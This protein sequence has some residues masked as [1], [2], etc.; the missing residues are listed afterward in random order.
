MRRLAE[1][2][3]RIRR[4]AV[5]A[6]SAIASSGFANAHTADEARAFAERAVAHIHDVGREQ[7]FADFSRPD[8]GFVDGELYIFC[9]DVTG[10]LL[11]S[12]GSPQMIGHNLADA[13]EPDG[14]RPVVEAIQLGLSQGSGWLDTPW[15]NPIKKRIELKSMYVL[16]VDDRTV[17]G[18]GIY[19]GAS[20]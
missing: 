17:C 7:A 20:P 18:S 3:C 12:G 14:R 1:Y 16:R 6:L 2:P 11:A 9:V 4:L 10:L 5:I 13:R 8:G 15:P 19:K